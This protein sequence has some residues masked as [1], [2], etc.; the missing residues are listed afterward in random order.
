[1]QIHPAASRREGLLA[2]EER[3]MRALRLMEWKSDPVLVE[4]EDPVPG[5]DQ[6]VVRIGSARVRVTRTC[7]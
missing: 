5:R 7:T 1:M 2:R 3:L 4:V 6:V